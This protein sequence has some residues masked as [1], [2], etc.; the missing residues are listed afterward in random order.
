MAM[1]VL[2]SSPLVGLMHDRAMPG[3]RNAG[4]APK[5]PLYYPG[6]PANRSPRRN[7]PVDHLHGASAENDWSSVRP[8]GG[9]GGSGN[10]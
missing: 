2:A 3:R 1:R 5:D 4:A 9:R 10:E 8:Y 6:T 7:R